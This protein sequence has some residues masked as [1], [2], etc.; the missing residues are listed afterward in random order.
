[1]RVQ[2]V[3]PGNTGAKSRRWSEQLPKSKLKHYLCYVLPIAL[4]V[5]AGCAAKSEPEPEAEPEKAIPMEVKALME[6]ATFE[7]RPLSVEALLKAGVPVD[8]RDQFGRTALMVAVGSYDNW[9][10]EKVAQVL[11]ENGADPNLQD[12]NGD[13]ALHWL[14][15]LPKCSAG[16]LKNMNLLLG[17]DADPTIRNKKGQA[18]FDVADENTCFPKMEMMV[19]Y[20]KERDKLK[21]QLEKGKGPAQ[22][23][24][25]TE[26]DLPEKKPTP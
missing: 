21:K 18:A 2:T 4:A 1:M 5:M 13:T 11:L 23:E 17:Y 16:N 14:V 7:C 8:S 25:I 15:R 10:P 24:N 19:L 3:S 12:N 22:K 26:K 6:G 20:L 9:C